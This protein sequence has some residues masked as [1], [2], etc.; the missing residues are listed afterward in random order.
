MM[1]WQDMLKERV[2][3]PVCFDDGSRALYATDAS[4]YRQMPLGVVLPENVDDVIATLD[5]CRTF[6]LPVLSR[7]GGTSLAGQCCNEAV[8]L[9]FSQHMTRIWDFDP[10]AKTIWVE[11]GVVLDELRDEVQP[12]GLTFGPDPSTHNHCTLG[13]MIGNNSC[14][15]HSVLAGR[16]AENVLELDILTYEGQRLRVG[17]GHDANDGTAANLYRDLRLFAEKYGPLIRK[18]FPN[19]PRRV[20]GYNLTALLDE[21]GFDVARSLVGSEGTCVVILGAKLRLIDWPPSRSIAII[22]FSDIF[23]AAEAVPNVLEYKPIGLEGM[24][25]Y[26]IECLRKNKLAEE[27]LKILPQGKGWL[28]A[29]FGGDSEEES[30][31]KAQHLLDGLRTKGRIVDGRVLRTEDQEEKIWKIRES[32][33]GATAR[34]PGEPDTWEGWEDSAVDPKRLAE[35][36]RE[37]TKLYGKYNLKGSLYGHFGDGCLHTRLN[38][39]FATEEG[40][41][42]YRQFIYEAAHLVN[43]M[44]GSYS[45]EHGDGQS[46][47]ELLPLM[48]GEELMEAFRRFKAIWDPRGKMNPGKLIDAYRMDENLRLDEAR[49]IPEVPTHFTFAEDQG[50]FGRATLR[51]V[52]VGECRRDKGGTMCPS[53]RVTREEAHTT[54][55]RAHLLFEMLNGHGLKGGWHDEAVK[56]S[57]HLCLACKGCKSDCPVRVDM[58]TYK[59]EF[60]SHYYQDRLRPRHA[61]AMGLIRNW[62]VLARKMPRLVNAVSHAPGLGNLVKWAGGVAQQREMPHFAPVTFRRWFEK[63]R[64]LPA[65]GQAVMLWPDTFTDH[66]TPE[67][68]KDA[69]FVLETLGFSVNL[70]ERELCCGRPLYDF[71]MLKKAKESLSDILD[72]FRDSAAR[73]LPIIGLEPSCVAVFRDELKNFFP[74]D[75]VAQ[76]LTRQVKTLNEFLNEQ[77]RDIELPRM[78]G[79]AVVHGHCHQKAVMGFKA[80]EKTFERLG[81]DFSILDS[82]CCGMAG[83]FGF[84]ASSYEVSVAVGEQCLLPAV[85]SAK[86]GTLII[87]DGFSCREQIQQLTGCKALHTAEVLAMALRGHTLPGAFNPS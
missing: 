21:N 35:Y 74:D 71:G 11:P 68:A 29:E 82:G 28:I 85:R 13:G 83:S 49:H 27:G 59:A 16:T 70:P 25:D 80:D 65:D 84:E 81:L 52:G 62:A 14:G 1:D 47:G 12:H 30:H 63:R 9:D 79:T 66:F 40:I 36:L 33:L 6:D 61:Y 64:A 55:G 5:V 77:G 8:V 86:R 39:N 37:L 26:L 10:E 78:E 19:I 57:L 50:H 54:R 60:L 75:P 23:T 51:C 31:A 76:R 20:S 32:S 18:K 38:F 45:G 34:I 53:Y 72:T 4:N 17:R 3:G 73:G 69:V 22:G 58:A 44:G 67:I 87:A 2:K 43:R 7:G 15:V 56:H 41:A 46:R 24:D 48:F 42:S